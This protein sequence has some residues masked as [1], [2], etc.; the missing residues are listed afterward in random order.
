MDAQPIAMSNDLSDR[1]VPLL[2]RYKWP[3][4]VIILPA[5]LSAAFL[6]GIVADQYISEAHFLVKKAEEGPAM[7]TGIGQAL[8]LVGGV[9]EGHSGMRIR[10]MKS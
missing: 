8:S 2:N 4:L 9:T 10:R 6:Y 7:P 1:M 3:F 5:L